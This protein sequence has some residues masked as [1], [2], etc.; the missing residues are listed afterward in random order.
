MKKIADAVLKARSWIA[1]DANAGFPSQIALE[2]VALYRSLI[3]PALAEK[4]EA[5]F[6]RNLE[7]LAEFFPNYLTDANYNSFA[8]A[9][10]FAE[11]DSLRARLQAAGEA[12]QHH[13]S[14][15]L[16]DDETALMRREVGDALTAR[17]SNLSPTGRVRISMQ[18]FARFEAPRVNSNYETFAAH[19]DAAPSLTL[20][21]GGWTAWVALGH[22]G[23][24][25]PALQ[26]VRRK[27]DSGL[28]TN[29]G[30]SISASALRPLRF[31]RPKFKP[32]DAAV[33]SEWTVHGTWVS[34]KMTRPRFSLDIRLVPV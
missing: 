29:G 9:L 20:E 10:A 31:E 5:R 21:R 27:F 12:N 17:F 26:Y 8:L 2:G 30:H 3:A 13:T 25:A 23:R 28:P 19:Q 6:K 32:G 22:C 18:S 33:F 14:A 15:Q 4:I 24:N 34:R 1:R 11:D 7:R 16:T